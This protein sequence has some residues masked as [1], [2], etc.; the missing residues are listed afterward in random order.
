MSA[1][2][3]MNFRVSRI[4]LLVLMLGLSACESLHYYGQAVGGHWELMRS[5]V[6]V[7]TAIADPDTPPELRE[8]LKMVVDARQF[9]S[10]TLRL[11]DNDSYLQYAPM[12][13]NAVT[14]NVVA[15]AEFSLK[16]QQWCFPVAGCVSYRGYFD[17][18]DAQ[19]KAHQLARQGMDVTITHAAAYST[20][21]WF[22]DP[23]P[24]PVLR[25]EDYRIIGLMFHE[26]AHQKLYIPD[27]T[28]FN[29]SYASAVAILGLR[30][31]QDSEGAAAQARQ[32]ARRRVHTLL[33]P[34]REALETLYASALTVQE[35]RQRKTAIFA[36]ARSRFIPLATD[37]PQ[38]QQWF[39]GLNNARLISLSDYTSGI[40]AFESLYRACKQDWA[41]FHQRSRDHGE[42]PR[43][44][45]QLF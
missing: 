39:D 33:E 14:Y 15:A 45:E 4:G 43:K 27:D 9:A 24:G 2:N 35:K 29:E 32:D 1:M 11:P 31:W 44:R 40:S 13:R 41:C 5:R 36:E 25:W 17:L 10:Q 19:E 42:D 26:L 12:T 8:K 3:F 18:Q 22:D 16:P 30:A 34:T 37:L 7:A 6:P 28:A 21:G 23:L 38:W 20:L